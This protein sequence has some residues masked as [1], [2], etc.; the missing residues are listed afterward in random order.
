VFCWAAA[1]PKFFFNNRP[2]QTNCV[3]RY[4]TA[5]HHRRELGLPKEPP[6]TCGLG[7]AERAERV[8]GLFS[9]FSLVARLSQTNKQRALVGARKGRRLVGLRARRARRVGP[10]ELRTGPGAVTQEA[11]NPTGFVQR[12]TAYT[13]ELRASTSFSAVG[14]GVAEQALVSRPAPRKHRFQPNLCLHVPVVLVLTV[15][16][17]CLVWF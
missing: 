12:C 4:N 13:G 6:P 2:T 8:P 16:T 17:R 3:G 5:N 11:S 14:K 15:R 9:R 1:K 10:A 7:L